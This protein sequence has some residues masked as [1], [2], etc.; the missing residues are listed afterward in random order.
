[1]ADYNWITPNQYNDMHTALT[2][3]YKG[4]T[5]DAANIKQGDDFL[6]QIVPVIMA[7]DAYKNHGVIIRWWDEAEGDGV[8]NDNADDYNHTNG[9]IVISTCACERERR[10]VCEPGEFHTFLRPADHAGNLP[11]RPT[12]SR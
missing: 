11:R 8:A 1:M 12:A 10:P 6:S 9:E 2:G 3:G 5:G 7:S 4:L